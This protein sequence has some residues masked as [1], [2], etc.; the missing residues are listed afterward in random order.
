[1]LLG[2]RREGVRL[3]W[4][5]RDLD[6]EFVLL[7]SFGE[8]PGVGVGHALAERRR[9]VVVDGAGLALDAA[10]GLLGRARDLHLAAV[11]VLAYPTSEPER[12]VP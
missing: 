3:E 6:G 2:S 10:H 12:P 1:M 9:G 5:P 4:A 11:A 8:L 7:G